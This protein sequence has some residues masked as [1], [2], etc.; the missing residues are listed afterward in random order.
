MWTIKNISSDITTKLQSH[1]KYLKEITDVQ[2]SAGMRFWVK[3]H[4]E[5]Q[6]LSR[7]VVFFNIL[8]KSI[9]QNG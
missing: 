3:V 8:V 2:P 5:L 9:T 6:W 7:F 1:G 4:L